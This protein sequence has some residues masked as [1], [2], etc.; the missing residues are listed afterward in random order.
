MWA[1][2]AQLINNVISHAIRNN[3][4]LKLSSLFDVVKAYDKTPNI[5]LIDAF[6]SI[7]FKRLYKIFPKIL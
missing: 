2:R 3:I 6:K 1:Q 4:K 5:G 7:G